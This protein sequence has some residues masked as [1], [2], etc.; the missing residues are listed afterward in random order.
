LFSIDV[1]NIKELAMP[2]FPLDLVR[3]VVMSGLE[4]AVS[5]NQVKINC[6]HF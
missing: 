3:E 6:F 2:S 1:N 4:H 5:V